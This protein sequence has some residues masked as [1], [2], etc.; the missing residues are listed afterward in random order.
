MDMPAHVG[1]YGG[2]G[3]GGRGGGGGGPPASTQ[4]RSACFGKYIAWQATLILLT[5]RAGWERMINKQPPC[6]EQWCGSILNWSAEFEKTKLYWQR[7]V[8]RFEG[9]RSS[10]DQHSP[11]N[12][13]TRSQTPPQTYAR[14]EIHRHLSKHSL[15]S[16]LFVFHHICVLHAVTQGSHKWNMNWRSISV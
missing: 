6:Q 3:G 14:T 9:K 5:L 11:F 15:Q 16:M 10:T 4:V 7:S 8:L 12:W 2:G 13:H 1:L